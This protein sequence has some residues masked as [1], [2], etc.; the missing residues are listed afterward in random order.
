[1]ARQGT[2]KITE[3]FF[4]IINVTKDDAWEITLTSLPTY[5]KKKSIRGDNICI[6]V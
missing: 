6:N 5:N 3:L 2:M 4:S 1:M